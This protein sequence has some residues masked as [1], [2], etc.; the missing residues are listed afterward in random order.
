MAIYIGLCILSIIFEV[1]E[2]IHNRRPLQFID[3]VCYNYT[4]MVL[5]QYVIVRCEPA[6]VASRYSSSSSVYVWWAAHE[7]KR[8]SPTTHAPTEY[9]YHLPTSLHQLDHWYKYFNNGFDARLWTRDIIIY[10]C[11]RY[12]SR[13]QRV[14]CD[15]RKD[16]DSCYVWLC[17]N[18]AR[19]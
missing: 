19:N 8:N 10:M 7:R 12:C 5:V 16:F 9:Y 4:S 6:W 2:P 11:N 17:S 1:R 18:L 3:T 14:I 15:I 13:H